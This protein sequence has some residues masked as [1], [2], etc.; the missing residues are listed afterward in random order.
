MDGSYRDGKGGGCADLKEIPPPQ[1]SPVDIR[2]DFG[3]MFDRSFPA[4]DLFFVFVFL[5]GD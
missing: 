4:C 5:G 3:R 1:L 2:F